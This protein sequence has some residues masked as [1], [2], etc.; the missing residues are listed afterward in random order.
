MG[1]TFLAAG[2]S[3]PEVV[4][5][6]IVTAQ[7]FGSMGFHNSIHSNVFDILLCLGLPWLI[8]TLIAPTVAGQP[9]VSENLES[10]ESFASFLLLFHS[11]RLFSSRRASRTRP[12]RFSP[13][14][15]LST[16]PSSSTAS[17]SIARS[18]SA[19]SRFICCFSSLR[20]LSSS[21]FSFPSSPS[22]TDTSPA[23]NDSIAPRHVNS[24]CDVCDDNLNLENDCSLMI[25]PPKRL[26]RHCC[27]VIVCARDKFMAFHIRGNIFPSSFSLHCARPFFPTRFIV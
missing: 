26:P 17:D 15:Q 3:M 18:A 2:T 6:V 7:G 9:W 27:A 25:K 21:T 16:S 12:S 14:S 22:I 11:L 23:E 20:C 4:S 19:A 24:F 5:S 1:L 8:K 13:L 10:L